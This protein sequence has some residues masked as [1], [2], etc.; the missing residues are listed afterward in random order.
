MAST[1]YKHVNQQLNLSNPDINHLTHACYVICSKDDPLPSLSLLHF[2]G[3]AKC[4]SV[5]AHPCLCHLAQGPLPILRKYGDQSP[6]FTSMGTFSPSS[7]WRGPQELLGHIMTKSSISQH[8][9]YVWILKLIQ[10][11][12]HNNIAYEYPIHTTKAHNQSSQLSNIH[13]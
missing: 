5:D 2:T 7:T 9:A 10:T 11:C 4:A 13:D 3:I 6:C 1:T 12:I 8:D